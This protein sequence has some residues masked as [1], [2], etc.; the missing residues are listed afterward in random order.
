[1]AFLQVEFFSSVLGKGMSMNVLLPQT[2]A[3]QIGV[4]GKAPD[5]RYPTL[6]LLHGMSDNHS[7]WMR[8]TAI[9]RFAQ[10]RGIAVVMPNADLS[11]YCNMEHGL[12][13]FSFIADELPAVCR[14]FFP[15]MSPDRED[16][17]IGG[18]SMGGYGALKIAF[19]RPERF[20]RAVAFSA[21]ADVGE[22]VKTT[23]ESRKPVLKSIFDDLEGVSGSEHDLFVAA[24]SL[25][26]SGKPLPR[27]WMWCGTEDGLCDLNKR[28][29]EAFSSLGYDLTSSLSPG[30]HNW[31]AWNE[32]IQHALDWL[33]KK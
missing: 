6:Y 28:A 18:L 13:Y 7:A 3:G 5:T 8:Y 10:E 16:T 1:M 14:D 23:Y 11:F 15:R 33:T 20:S 22:F 4:D 19:A 31:F 27:L 32:Q 26:E 12:N 25:A 24:R 17:F 2:A 21:V 29:M 30:V 9:E